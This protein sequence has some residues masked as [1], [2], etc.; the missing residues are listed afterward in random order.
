[1]MQLYS[2]SEQSFKTMGGYY[3]NTGMQEFSSN[4]IGLSGQIRFILETT[5]SVGAFCFQAKWE[6]QQN[7]KKG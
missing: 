3:E 1:M 2:K 5:A 6:L 4:I 7:P